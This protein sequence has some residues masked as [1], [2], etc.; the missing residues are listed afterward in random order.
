DHPPA[1]YHPASLV[2]HDSK[3]G[4]RGA[5]NRHDVSV[6]AGCHGAQTFFHPQQCRAVLAGCAVW[7][8]HEDVVPRSLYGLI[9]AHL[10]ILGLGLGLGPWTAD[11]HHPPLG[12]GGYDRQTLRTLLCVP[13]W[14]P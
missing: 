9:M 5:C 6:I 3:A 7:H 4:T 13:G 1:V 8:L 10:R 2:A 11:H 14:P 12:N